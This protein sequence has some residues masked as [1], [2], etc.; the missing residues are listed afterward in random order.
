MG[1]E[2]LRAAVGPEVFLLACGAPLGSVLGLVEAN[3]IGADVS[4]TWKPNFSGV[5]IGLGNEPHMPSASISIHNIIT[6][7]FLHRNFWLNDPDCLLVRPDTELTLAEVQTLATVIALTGGSLLLSD[8]LPKLPAERIEIACSLIPVIDRRAWVVDWMDAQTPAHIRL[9]LEGVQGRWHVLACFNWSEKTAPV[10]VDLKDY[11]LPESEYY[12]RPFWAGKT[13][14][15]K[16]EKPLVIP[17]VP[18]HGVVLLA[19]RMKKPGEAQYIGSSLHISQGLELME[20]NPTEAGVELKL[21]L[22]RQAHGDVEVSLPRPPR[23]AR[24]DGV[25]IPW[26]S[27]GDTLY[28]F[29]VEFASVCCLQVEY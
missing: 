6:R 2:A 15:L 14:I 28:A 18:A 1:M 24:V 20:W 29:T 3:R 7:A 21:A 19:V 4:G 11:R 22:P 5:K 25:P 9:D 8:D 17:D 16:M 10:T 27:L 23:I 12:A 26:R 13:S